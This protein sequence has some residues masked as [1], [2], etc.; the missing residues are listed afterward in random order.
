M[1][2]CSGL[3]HAA[4]YIPLLLQC[5]CMRILHPVQPLIACLVDFP[6]LNPCLSVLL[7]AVRHP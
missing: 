2:R 5:A 1:S 7:L 4:T 6:L 3:V